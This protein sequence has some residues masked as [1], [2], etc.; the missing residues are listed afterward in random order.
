MEVLF[1]NQ[2]HFIMY[3]SERCITVCRVQYNSF[4]FEWCTRRV[5]QTPLFSRGRRESAPS[6][7]HLRNVKPFTFLNTI[8][9][10]QPSLA[11]HPAAASR[12]PHAPF[13]QSPFP[14]SAILSRPLRGPVLDPPIILTLTA[15]LHI[16]LICLPNTFPLETASRSR[17][18]K[19]L[20]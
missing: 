3:S 4:N 6:H 11:D 20:N 12:L 18:L 9:V 8:A 19:T 5:P 1:R 14:H 2:S 16:Y 13:P 17:R 10:Q 7:A 15:K